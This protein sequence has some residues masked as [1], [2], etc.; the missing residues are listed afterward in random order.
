M[1]SKKTTC[2]PF[3]QNDAQVIMKRLAGLVCSTRYDI[4]IYSS[5]QIRHDLNRTDQTKQGL[6]STDP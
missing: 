6:E 5:N 4:R 1:D 3:N 2:A